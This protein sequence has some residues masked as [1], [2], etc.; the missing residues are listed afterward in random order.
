MPKSNRNGCKIG[1]Q[2]NLLVQGTRGAVQ[3]PQITVETKTL[4]KQQGK[5]HF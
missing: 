2:N 4:S 1:K 5:C 3:K